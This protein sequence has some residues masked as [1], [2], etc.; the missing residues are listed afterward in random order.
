MRISNIRRVA[1]RGAVRV[2]ADVFWEDTARAPREIWFEVGEDRAEGFAPAGEAFL[3]VCLPLA[4]RQGERRIRVEGRVCPGLRDGAGAAARLLGSW[5][6]AKH[7]EIAIEAEDGFSAEPREGEGIA[8]SFLTGGVDSTFTLL[9]NHRAFEEGHPQRIRE[10]ILVSGLFA[11]EADSSDLAAEFDGRVRR[12]ASAVAASAGIP[13]T[14]VRTN[15]RELEPGFDFF[16]RELHGA[17]L[18]SVAHLLAGRISSARIAATTTIR[19]LVPSGTHP[20]LDPLWSSSRVE[21]AHDG[22]GLTRVEKMAALASWPETLENL[23]VCQAGPVPDGYFN[24]GRCE[25]CVRTLLCFLAAGALDRARSF[26]RREVSPRIV[27]RGRFDSEVAN[28]WR[29]LRKAFCR[30]G[31]RA[32]SAAIALKLIRSCLDPPRRVESPETYGA[33]TN[34]P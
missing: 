11:S 10:A 32:L 17:L 4:L 13:L 28:Q 8:A 23:M 21:I 9:A 14:I 5:Y 19:H 33:R 30:R 25:K 2:V 12:S 31:L 7:E 24:C 26:R 29:P 16:A 20:L 6:G 18:A 34:R 22:F 3:P 15:A 27:L 1:S